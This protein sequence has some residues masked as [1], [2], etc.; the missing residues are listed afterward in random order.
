MLVGRLALVGAGRDRVYVEIDE[1]AG[2]CTLSGGIELDLGLF[3]DLPLDGSREIRI[4][5]VEVPAGLEPAAKSGVIDEEQIAAIRRHDEGAGGEMAGHEVLPGEDVAREAH[6]LEHARLMCALAGVDR[7]VALDR[8]PDLVSPPL[9][10]CSWFRHR[11][12]LRL[13][14]LAACDRARIL[15]RSTVCRLRSPPHDA[16]TA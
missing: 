8:L 6:E 7:R 13:L 4:G 15:T 2:R 11:H 3:P 10:G 12:H 14:H 9:A 5:G 1:S 16:R